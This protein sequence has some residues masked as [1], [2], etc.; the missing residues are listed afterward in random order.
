[1]PKIDV[2]LSWS[3]RK[4][5]ILARKI[6]EWLPSIVS[7]DVS[8]FFSPNIEPGAMWSNEIAAAVR[9]SRFAILCVTRDSLSSP[10]LQFEAGAVWRGAETGNVCSL[11]FEVSADDLPAP[12]KLFH[13]KEFNESGFREVCKLL[14]RKTGVEGDRLRLNFK[15]LWP[16]LDREVQNDLRNL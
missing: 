4:G 14:G 8:S 1:M 7:N 15:G 13:A 16:T 5:E 6:H 9:K 2:F 3:G 10:W 11:L 12:L